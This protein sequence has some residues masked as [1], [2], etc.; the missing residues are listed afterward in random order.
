[1]YMYVRAYEEVSSIMCLVT[2]ALLRKCLVI[3]DLLRGWVVDR[4]GSIACRCVRVYK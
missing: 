4:A 1:M 3:G 2:A